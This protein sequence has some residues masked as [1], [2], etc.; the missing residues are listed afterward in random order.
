MNK[1]IERKAKRLLARLIAPFLRGRPI[2]PEEFNRLTVSR[3]LVIRQHNQMGDMLL[4]VPALRGLRRRFPGARITLVAAP[5]NAAVAERNPFVDEVL[6]YEKRRGRRN[7]LAP[8][9]FAAELRRRRFD[10][11][12]VLNT[13]SF[14]ITSMLLAAASG[15]RVRV[16][17]TSR[18]FGHDL[19][20]RF[21]H[22]ELPL[23]PPEELARMHESRHNIFPLAAI[24]VEED[25]LKSEIAPSA[26]E[27]RD[28]ER[29]VEAVTDSRRPFIVVHPGAGKRQNIWPPERF[30]AAAA[31]LHERHGAAVIAVRGPVDGPA[32]DAF[33]AACSVRP[34][35]LLSPSVGFLASLMRKAACTLCN[36]TGIMHIAGAV[37]ARCVAVFGPTDPL[38]WKPVNETVVAVRAENGLVESVTVEEVVA[39]AERLLAR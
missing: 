23:P 27:I 8:L 13:V 28:A 2:T 22:L 9:L 17:S 1:R 24:G 31:L 21:Y 3:L 37:A 29:F 18:P 32:S 5:I 39:A 30:A 11:V 10:A 12:I 35:L 14:S 16:G 7:P 20:A 19:S 4:A 26:R 36:D 38:R 6:T 33:L 34:A 25:D 15:A